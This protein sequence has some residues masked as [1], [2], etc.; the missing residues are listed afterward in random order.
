MSTEKGTEFLQWALPELGYRWDGFRKPRGQVLKRIRDRIRE[1][2][3]SGG[4]DEYKEYLQN[5]PEEWENLDELCDVTISKFFRDRNV[6]EFLRDDILPH[7]CD[8]KN[9]DA[10]FIWS[11]G[12]CNG[13]EPYSLAIILDQL[14]GK[15]SGEIDYTILATDRNSEVLKRAKAG[16]FPE[17]ALKELREE[18]IRNFF[19]ALENDPE[20]YRIRKQLSENVQFEQRDIRD[21]L[22]PGEFDMVFCRNL[23]FTYFNRQM[24]EIFLQRL[25]ERVCKDGFLI[26]GSNESIPPVQWLNQVVTTYPVFKVQ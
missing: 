16:R 8:R 15:I 12:C 5:H 19:L 14:S 9:G 2:K 25:H 10:L 24:Q 1:L 13:E 18:E 20:A 26:T 11:C 6:W 3:L 21:S 7:I 17:S 23:V 22:P 4:F